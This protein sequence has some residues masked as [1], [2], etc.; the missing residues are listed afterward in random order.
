MNKDR[1]IAQ[2]RLRVLEQGVYLEFS[3]AQFFHKTNN[4]GLIFIREINGC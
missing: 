1:R 2:M 3:I 4:R